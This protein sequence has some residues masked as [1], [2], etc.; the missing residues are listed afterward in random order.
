MKKIIIASTFISIF[1]VFS[2]FATTMNLDASP[3]TG[4]DNQWNTGGTDVG[5]DCSEQG[6][7]E[8]NCTK[9]NLLLDVEFDNHAGGVGSITK[10]TIRA[11]AKADINTPAG[12]GIALRIELNYDPSLGTTHSLTTLYDYYETD[13]DLTPAGGSWTWDD[14]NNVH[15]G[16]KSI[17]A[18]WDQIDVDHLEMVVTYIGPPTLVDTNDAE[19]FTSATC[20]QRTDGSGDIEM[21]YDISDDNYSTVTIKAEFWDSS[22]PTPAWV[23]CSDAT[24]TGE[25]SVDADNPGTNRQLIWDAATQLGTTTEVSDYNMQIIAVNAIPLTDTLK[26]SSNDFIIDTQDPSTPACSDPADQETPGGPNVTVTSTVA[27]DAS[28]VSYYFEIDD[29]YPFATAIDNS[30]WQ[31][32]DNDWVAAGLTTSQLYSWRVKARDVYG[33]ETPFTATEFRFTVSNVK[34]SVVIDNVTHATD[35]SGEITIQYDLSDPQGSQDDCTILI[36]HSIDDGNTWSQSYVITPS[37]GDDDNAG[38][39]TNSSTGQITAITPNKTNETFIWDSQNS[40]NYNG[41]IT[42]EYDGIAK[43]SITPD[44]GTNTGNT[45]TS[46]GFTLDNKAPTGYGCDTPLDGATNTS[47]LPTLTSLTTSDIS[48]IQYYFE[49]DDADPF[50]TAIE[51]SGWQ[52]GATWQTSALTA[53]TT[54]AWRVNAKDSYGNTGTASFDSAFT[55]GSAKWIYPP[56]GTIGATT[57]PVI[58]DGRVY[59]GTGGA[60]QQIHCIDIDD[61]SELWTYDASGGMAG[62]VNTICLYYHSVQGKYA[63]YYT[64]TAGQIGAIW[65]NGDNATAKFTPDDMGN[66]EPSEPII[67]PDGDYVYLM[68]NNLGKKISASDGSTLWSTAGIAA[69][70]ASAAV[71]ENANVYFPADGSVYKYLLNGNP[72]GDDEAVGTSEPLGIWSGVLYVATATTVKAVSTSTMNT[73]STSPTYTINTGAFRQGSYVY[74][75][76]GSTV[77]QLNSSDLTYN[78]SFSA[79]GAVNSM[80]IASGSGYVYFGDDN[81][82]AFSVTASGMTSNWSKSTDENIPN[83]PAVDVANGVVVFASSN[84]TVGKVY[85]YPL[86]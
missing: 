61:G 63:I 21:N 47:I 1:A 58:G 27:S 65:D 60:D 46:I 53:S 73:V 76:D 80:P 34:P 82:T 36:K 69:S 39:N 66:A 18:S 72:S 84:G 51:N 40:L 33:N 67:A 37:T 6:G 68:Y 13:F 8:A 48:T 75:G 57:A 31:S 7:T 2:S 70:E 38:V 28:T 15:G 23:A 86:P 74:V 16:C 22:L 20:L 26:F 54:H 55:P 24:L 79:G 42:D 19:S 4:D 3:G 45:T 29:A 10:I 12:D 52:S 43:I 44:D 32:D 11:Y 41:A 78:A 62:D 30:G 81:S 64:N 25:G 85:A 5:T 9:K 71:V 59:L 17:D 56:T 49:I 35:G 50:A 83:T 14:I 77:K